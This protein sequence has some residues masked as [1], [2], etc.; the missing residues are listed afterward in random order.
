Y[1]KYC[2]VKHA[3]GVANG[4]DALIL[5]IRAYKEMG[6]FNEGDEI[7]VPSIN[8]LL[9]PIEHPLLRIVRSNRSGYT[10]DLGTKSLVNVTL[11]LPGCV[12]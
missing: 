2:G 3:I 1:A 7:I 6:I 5:I 8:V 11:G 10:L 12:N 9:A 4:L